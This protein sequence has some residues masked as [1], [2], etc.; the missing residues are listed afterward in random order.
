[1]NPEIEKLID[2]AI[3]DGQITEKERNVIL[4]KAAELG[5]DL[6]E[7]E[8]VLDGRL[9]QLDASKSKQKEKVGNIKTCPACGASVKAFQ[10][11]CED[12]GHEFTG[13]KSNHTITQLL[14]KLNSL[15]KKA[16]ELDHEFDERKAGIINSTPIPTSKE[17]ILEFLSVCSSQ[18]DVDFMSRGYGYVVSAWANKGNEALLKAKILFRNDSE[19][20]TL[21]L[22]F[23]KKLKK[24]EKKSK[25]LW[26][27]VLFFALILGSLIYFNK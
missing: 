22:D 23:E 21:L 6:D 5:I 8:M 20:Y 4:K 19:T 24:S 25:Y 10:I 26:F 7:V 9:H 18:A 3:A 27:I 1:M 13:V 15:N 2:L 14:D 12:C 17:D 16:N 11:K